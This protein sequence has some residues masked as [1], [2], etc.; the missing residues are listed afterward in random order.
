MS[1]SW[2]KKSLTACVLVGLVVA[3][4]A[5]LPAKETALVQGA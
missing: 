4:A 3:A 1:S 2:I 5:E